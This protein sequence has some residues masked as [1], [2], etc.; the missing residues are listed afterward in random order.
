MNYDWAD[1]AE[2]LEERFHRLADRWKADPEV[3]LSS[4]ITKKSQHPDYQ[5]IIAMGWE[6]VPLILRELAI[7]PGHWFVAL[8]AITGEN[9]VPEDCHGNLPKMT[10][11]WLAWGKNR[12]LI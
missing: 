10:E 4:S 6:V 12:G 9:P 2:S 11:H 8:H 1:G 3:F 5:A 7:K